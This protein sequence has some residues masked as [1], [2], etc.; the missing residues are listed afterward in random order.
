[1]GLAGSCLS[2]FHTAAASETSGPKKS[3][4]VFDATAYSKKPALKTL[5]IR[6]LPAVHAFFQEGEDLDRLPSYGRIKELAFHAKASGSD[7]CFLDL[8]HWPTKEAAGD[9][10]AGLNK[11]RQLLMQFKQLAPGIKVGYYSHPPVSDYWRAVKDPVTRE[12][13]EWQRDNDRL[14]HLAAEVDVFY[15]SLYTFY[16]DSRGWG[17][18]AAAQIR[19]ARSYPGDKPVYAFL[20]PQYH[21]SNKLLAHQFIPTGFWRFQLDT[22]RKHADGVV[23]WGGWDFDRDQPLPWDES[24]PWWIETKFFLHLNRA[25]M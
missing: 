12:Y 7:I 21:G 22:V 10:V 2:P 4:I 11:Y 13:R 9:W 6:P 14:K 19:E 17:R 18:Y 16:N 8:E 20:W 25:G 3:F 23:I 24:A 15:P 5:G 1:M